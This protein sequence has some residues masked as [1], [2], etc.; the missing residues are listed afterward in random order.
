MGENPVERKHA[1]AMHGCVKIKCQDDANLRAGISVL[2]SATID[3]V[4]CE[5]LIPEQYIIAFFHLA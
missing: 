5:M 3:L 2:A 4:Y 1:R